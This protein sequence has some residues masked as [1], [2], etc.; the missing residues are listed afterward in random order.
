MEKC[1]FIGYPQGYKAWTFYNPMSKKVII[2][3]RANFDERFFLNK[4]NS[5]QL[6]PPHPESLLDPSHIP[7]HLPEYLDD[8]L[9]DS[10]SS[11]KPVHG[12]DR[13]TS[14]DL[15][16]APAEAPLAPL[17]YS[18][19]P[20]SPTQFHTAPSLSTPFISA[21]PSPPASPVQ[22]PDAPSCPQQT[23]HPRAE[24]LPEQWTVP[25]H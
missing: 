11:Q 5:T 10:P 15:P 6:C 14:S 23:C 25:Q 18:V 17:A 20:P 3:E 7:V 16:S 13:S 19:T 2:S 4:K 9:D 12:G 1:V 21:S 24:W 22:P 8:T